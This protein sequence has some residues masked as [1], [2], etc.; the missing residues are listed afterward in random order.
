M[1]QLRAV[2]SAM[3]SAQAILMR[4]AVAGLSKVKSVV[5]PQ[6]LLQEGSDITVCHVMSC[7]IM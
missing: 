3:L 2:T 6:S 1:S 5:T 7:D 4:S